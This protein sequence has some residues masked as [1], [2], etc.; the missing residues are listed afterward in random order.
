MRGVE[1]CLANRRC[2]LENDDVSMNTSKWAWA[3]NGKWT[4]YCLANRWRVLENGHIS[5]STSKWSHEHIE[6]W[7]RYVFRN[8][9]TIRMTLNYMDECS[10]KRTHI[11]EDRATESLQQWC[12]LS[13][14]TAPQ[15]T[16]IP[17]TLCAEHT[18]SFLDIP[19]LFYDSVKPGAA[20]RLNEA[21]LLFGA[22]E[23]DLRLICCSMN[24]Q[25]FTLDLLT[26]KKGRYHFFPSEQTK[27]NQKCQTARKVQTLSAYWAESNPVTASAW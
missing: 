8:K 20:D 18:N 9:M 7:T 26:S 1:P 6:K 25:T 15:K 23:A 11:F 10:G 21:D 22:A 12:R 3:F 27:E 13:G 17:L 16:P 24:E 2:L 5:M 14:S 4:R 19:K